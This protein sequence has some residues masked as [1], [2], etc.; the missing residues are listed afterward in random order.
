LY[1]PFRVNRGEKLLTIIRLSPSQT[2]DALQVAAHG[3]I[4]R[5]EPGPQE[6]YGV[7]IEFMHYRCIEG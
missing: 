2:V 7:A 1:L 5:V 3:R 4:V 6:M